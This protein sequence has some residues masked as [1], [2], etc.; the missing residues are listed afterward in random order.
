MAAQGRVLVVDDEP[1]V[2][3][4]LTRYLE[5]DGFEVETAA[6]GEDAIA[7]FDAAA[8]DLVLLDLMLPRLDGFEVF[9][10]IRSRS[11]SPVIMLTARGDVT[12]RIVG[13]DVGA[14]DY[15]SKP[16]SPSEVAARVR[17][18]IRRTHRAGPGAAEEAG[19]VLRFDGLE[20]E[21]RTREV[22]VEGTSVRLTPKE[23][24][25]LHLLASSPRVVFSRY[26]LLDELWDV[27]FDGDPSTVTVH[28]RRLREKVERD[29][30]NPRH[31]IT[32]WGAGYRFEP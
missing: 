16:F 5:R 26:Q 10:A 2:R 13:L 23:F 30:S 32:V 6:D 20:I 9:R 17:A 28:V 7:R 25:L 15:V 18:V 22:R 27:A 31:L 11:Q 8:P 1:V 3:E 21:P 14:D 12:D 29:P 4:V 19:A 24:D